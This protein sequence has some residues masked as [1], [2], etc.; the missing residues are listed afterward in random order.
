MNSQR[1][2]SSNI[3]LRRRQTTARA[4]PT[5]RKGTN[6]T[7]GRPAELMVQSHLTH[8]PVISRLEG[9]KGTE[10]VRLDFDAADSKAST[11]ESEETQHVERQA[12]DS[13]NG[14]SP[15]LLV[16]PNLEVLPVVKTEQAIGAF[17]F[18]VNSYATSIIEVSSQNVGSYSHVIHQILHDELLFT[19]FTTTS[20][21]ARWRC[22]SLYDDAPLSV[23]KGYGKTISLLSQRL[24]SE[25]FAMSPTIL[26]TMG[27]LVAIE[28]L[29][30]NVSATARH[31][32]GMQAAM[33]P[34]NNV[35]P[36]EGSSRVL[37]ATDIWSQYFKH[38]AMIK[39]TISRTDP[40]T[41]PKHP[42][43]PKLSMQIAD[44]PAGFSDL[45]LSGRISTQ[46]LQLLEHFN[47]YSIK[48][49]HLNE[50]GT[51][52]SPERTQIIL[53]QVAYCI[54]FHQIQHLSTIER[55]ILTALTAYVMR[56]DRVHPALVNGRNYFQI[57]CAYQ[58]NL[59]SSAENGVDQQ[60]Q[61][62]DLLAWVGLMLLLT[63]TAEA[64]ARK[65]ALKLLPRRPEP[66]KI[67]KKCQQFFWD[68]DL[69]N[70]LL[71]GN[72][73]ATN[74]SNDIIA[75]NIKQALPGSDD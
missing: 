52:D 22:Q 33:K 7:H 40:L 47:T 12:T 64:H 17:D 8:L 38:R 34:K 32:A 59:L 49:S 25:R 31:L 15:T 30:K 63:S 21:A 68:D 5:T 9:L 6:S 18:Y 44:L 62:S 20:E 29:I 41:Y 72:V 65:L 45:A 54:E 24:R 69:T 53:R 3:G 16:N 75:D 27:Q 37:S 66:L 55:L 50:E 60:D 1:K 14:S 73:L 2:Q 74:A 26:L 58:A 4:M 42:F 46:I 36:P 35:E 61:G 57:T 48:L 51:F 56:R 23:A 43:N 28:I 39:S 67:L 10:L 70:A 71:S 13:D 11:P 19:A